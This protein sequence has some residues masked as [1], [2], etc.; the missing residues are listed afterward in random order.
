MHYQEITSCRLCGSSRLETVLHLGNQKLTGVFPRSV[1]D[2][3]ISGPLEL[4]RCVPDGDLSCGLLQLRHS[5]P[6]AAMYGENYGYRSGLNNSMVRHLEGKTKRLLNLVNP[7]EGSLL[8]DIGSNDGTLLNSYPKNFRRTGIDPVAKKFLRFYDP[9]IEVVPDFFSADS[10]NMN[11]GEIKASIITSVAMFYDLERPLEFVEEIAA[12]LAPE[13]VWHFEQ[14]YMPLMLKNMAYDTI[15]HEHIEYYALRQISWAL[16]KC[17][18][19]IIALDPSDV[20]GGSLAVTAALSNS[21]YPEPTEMIKSL[22]D[23]EKSQGLEG[24][25]PFFEFR[26]NVFRHR[27]A[28]KSKIQVLKNSGL[29]V[30]GYGASTKGNV[31]LQ[32]CEFTKEDIAMIGEVNPDKF[33]A[34]TPGTHIPIVSE[35]VMHNEKPDILL[36]LPWH[37]RESIIARERDFIQRGGRLLFPLPQIELFPA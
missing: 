5:Y 10:W 3:L 17:S 2:D 11:L 12:H 36:V 33:G 21:R 15:C 24:M 34:S 18:L 28:I 16:R 14:S 20:N 9:L 26:D 23:Q 29:K 32:F 19:K 30:F 4:V 22:L 31:I 7:S 27:D 13:G 1:D 37:F 6:Q 35:K 8:V 25:A